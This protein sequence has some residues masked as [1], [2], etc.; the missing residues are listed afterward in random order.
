MRGFGKYRLLEPIASGGMA[1][2]WRAEVT[3]AAGVVKE[4]ALKLVRGEHA[5][6][7]DFVRMFVEEARLAS[8]LGHANVVQVFEFDQIDGR[9]YIAMELVRG[10]HLGHVADRAREIG[11]RFGV[12]RVLQVG[13]DVARGLAHAHRLSEAGRPLGVVH[14]DVSPHNVL[15][16]FEG[17]VKLTDF[18]I[19]R[20]MD[21]AG[22]SAP[23][24]IKGKAAFMAP[25]QARG[26]GV[27]DARADVFSLGVILW[28][29][30]TGRRLFARDSDQATLEAVK[31]GEPVTPPSSWNEEVPPALDRAILAALE[32]EATRR[33]ASA[34]ELGAALSTILLDVATSPDD[35]DLR[36]FMHRLFEPELAVLHSPAAEPTRVRP[37]AHAAEPE[38]SWAGE[39]TE[40]PTRT[41][42]G[43]PAP[44]R[45][46]AAALVA[47]MAAALAVAGA[48][49]VAVTKATSVPAPAPRVAPPGPAV[50]AAPAAPQLPAPPVTQAARPLPD[51]LPGVTDEDTGD[52]EPSTRRPVHAVHG[53]NAIAVPP[54]ASGDGIL[55]VNA[56]PWG[57]VS[58]NGHAVG[59]T[60]QEM[61]LPA[62]RHRVR[63]ERMGHRTVDELVTVRAGARTKLLR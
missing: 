37:A 36:A 9:Y 26:D 45:R 32:H 17:E 18:G 7:S 19:A 33:T 34:H 8:R 41:A 16:S 48:L 47:G 13:V 61:R 52:R 30:C 63:I 40:P 11:V 21:R 23:G 60:P 28:E 2:V 38:A 46:R 43:P 5:E 27:V 58:V 54:R 15:L 56:I 31:A 39:G 59:D 14:R 1:D 6:R 42:L 10:R 62:G 51:E 35:H 4:V 50:A 12:P 49:A 29:L 20:A 25:E 57:T 53:L 22:L 44:R 3:G 24:T 55:S